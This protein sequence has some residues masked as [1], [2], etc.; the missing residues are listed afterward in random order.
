M[1]RHIADDYALW[2]REAIMAR[3]DE[4]ADRIIT[5]WPGPSAFVTAPETNP[6]W[7]ALAQVLA[8]IPA[9]AWTTYSDLAAVIGT[10]QVPLGQRLANHPAPNAHRVLKS[11]GI[12]AA[13][14][15][16]LEPDR[17]DDPRTILEAEGVEFDEAGRANPA[18]RLDAEDLAVLAGLDTDGFE[19]SDGDAATSNDRRGRFVSQV[20]ERQ[21]PDVV[22][23]LVELLRAWT[24]LGGELDFGTS[25]ETSCF[26]MPST[27]SRPPWPFTIYPSGKVEVVFQHM[28][29]RPPFDDVEAREHFRELLNNIAGIDLPASKIELRPGFPMEV[30]QHPDRR[31]AVIEALA[32]FIATVRTS[33]VTEHRADGRG[34][35]ALQTAGPSE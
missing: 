7:T 2:G 31:D 24:H 20:E 14:F 5:T 23:G 17:T 22:N 4:L 6:T 8:E 12:I 10:H 11:G 26:L 3:S 32:W 29:S 13:N 34:R 19:E 33:D 21:S 30:L 35:S 1:N 15:R 27:G 9:G 28:A 18:Q 16:W 25:E